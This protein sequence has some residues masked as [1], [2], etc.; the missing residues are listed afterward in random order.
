MKAHFD[1]I[2]LSLNY[3]NTRIHI[4]TII[5]DRFGGKDSEP[6]YF[7]CSFKNDYSVTKQN[8]EKY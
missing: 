6:M 3:H 2:F 5:L 4:R 7:G 1:I 8:V